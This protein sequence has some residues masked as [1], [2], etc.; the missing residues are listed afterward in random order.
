[1]CA[2]VFIYFSGS[3]F[4]FDIFIG[5]TS[6]CARLAP[7]RMVEAAEGIKPEQFW[8]QPPIS[9]FDLRFELSR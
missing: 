7:H 1:M 4:I 8:A 3:T 6:L 9:V 5:A 2:F